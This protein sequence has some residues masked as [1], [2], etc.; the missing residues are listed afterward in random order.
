M[1]TFYKESHYLFTHSFPLSTAH[2][3]DSRQSKPPP[4]A[5]RLRRKGVAFKRQQKLICTCI[6]SDSNGLNCLIKQPSPSQ[7]LRYRWRRFFFFPKG[8]P[9]LFNFPTDAASAEKTERIQ[10][11]PSVSERARGGVRMVIYIFFETLE[12]VSNPLSESGS[13]LVA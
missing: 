12:Q 11:S 10:S 1:S 3:C 13:P 5:R 7:V 8:S 4:R 9:S 2:F 6:Y